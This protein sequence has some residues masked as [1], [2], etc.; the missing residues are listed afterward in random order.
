MTP[1]LIV[2]APRSGSTWL[3]TMISQH[4]D[5]HCLEEVFGRGPRNAPLLRAMEDPVAFLA[6]EVY[7]SPRLAAGFKLL[8]YQ[9]WERREL[10]AREYLRNMPVRFIEPVRRNVVRR[11]LSDL[12]AQTTNRYHARR[13]GERTTIV[14]DPDP[15]E[16]LA[17]VKQKEQAVERERQFFAGNERL[18]VIYE[19]LDETG[20]APVWEFLGVRPFRPARLLF[21]MEQ[22][23]LREI[24]KR[25]EEFEPIVRPHYP[26]CFDD[27]G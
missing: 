16:F 23:P 3:Q 9:G 12:A 13:A 11:E 4:P 14:L 18:T 26:H 7:S 21:Q 20:L 17:R 5:V 25:F 27:E 19:S 15:R 22:R 8:T 1:F 24:V 2:S 6:A 10:P